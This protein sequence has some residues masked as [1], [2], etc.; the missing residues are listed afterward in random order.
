MKKW[1]VGGVIGCHGFHGPEK[2]RI[3]VIKY[4]RVYCI[5]ISIHFNLLC[6]KMNFVRKNTQKTLYTNENR[7]V[8]SILN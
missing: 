3:Q 7:L 6:I 4:G 2:Q 8:Y 1:G 5:F